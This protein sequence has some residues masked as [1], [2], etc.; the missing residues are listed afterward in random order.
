M[1][2]IWKFLFVLMLV[3]T[4]PM[5]IAG[6][7]YDERVIVEFDSR[8][9]HVDFANA[10]QSE[11]IVEYTLRGE[12]VEKWTELVT[13]TMFPVGNRDKELQALYDYYYENARKGCKDMYWEELYK[14]KSQFIVAWNHESCLGTAKAEYTMVA[15]TRGKRCVHTVM[16]AA[17]K[18]SVFEANKATWL[19]LLKQA[20]VFTT[21]TQDF[22]DQETLLSDASKMIYCLYSFDS[23]TVPDNSFYK[24]PKRLWRSGTVNSRY[25]EEIDRANKRQVL[26]VVDEPD[27]WFVN[28]SDKTGSHFLDKV[29]P[30]KT[31]CPVFG[32]RKDNGLQS[33]EFGM[34]EAF[35]KFHGARQLPDE[36]VE[37]EDCYVYELP[38]LYWVLRLY[39]CKDT[40]LPFKLYRHGP[41]KVENSIYYLEYIKDLPLDMTLFSEPSR[42]EFREN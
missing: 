29:P 24:V 17:K 20:T 38:R 28:L 4:A 10:T 13:T 41:D 11:F 25:E 37:S 7:I 34:E 42:I 16:Y 2:K 1:S 40:G 31:S 18:K 19:E 30:Y 9:W 33:L 32:E 26:L 36:R 22:S 14:S 15:F 3:C 6:E 23:P 5:L 8:E 27:C 39:V 12:T 21:G 35:F